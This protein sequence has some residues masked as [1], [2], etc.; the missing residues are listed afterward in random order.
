MAEMEDT[1]ASGDVQV[2][3]TNNVGLANRPQ[4]D[5]VHDQHSPA[6]KA[7]FVTI[8]AICGIPA[9]MSSTGSLIA[10]ENIAESFATSASVVNISNGVYIAMMGIS[11]VI[12]GPLSTLVG[13]RIVVYTGSLIFFLC[14]VGTALAPNLAVFFVTRLL[15]GAGG[16]AVLIAGSGCIGDLYRPVGSTSPR[17]DGI[18]LDEALLT[19][20]TLFRRNVPRPWG[21]LS[22]G[23][24][25]DQQLVRTSSW[26]GRELKFAVF[27]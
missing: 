6:K 16:T 7:L 4:D 8:L 2:L 21:G 24:Y 12:W 11:A 5:D 26:T 13:R 25:S 3:P 1:K 10:A 22:L 19:F 18:A 9:P 27:C 20:D 15:C 23:R 17:L 14:S